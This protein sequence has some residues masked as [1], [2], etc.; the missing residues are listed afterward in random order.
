[1]ADYERNLEK[2]LNKMAEVREKNKELTIKM[3]V[4]LSTREKKNKMQGADVTNIWGAF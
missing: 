2:F 3:Q 1:M 4:W